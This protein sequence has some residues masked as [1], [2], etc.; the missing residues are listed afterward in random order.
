[1][2]FGDQIKKK[3]NNNNK[4]MMKQLLS[5]PASYHHLLYV[6]GGI[7]VLGGGRGL[8]IPIRTTPQVE[9][10]F[11]IQIGRGKLKFLFSNSRRIVKF[12]FHL[13]IIFGEPKKKKHISAVYRR[14]ALFSKFNSYVYCFVFKNVKLIVIL[15]RYV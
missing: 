9:I 11:Q 6:K 2:T 13:K 3:N 10:E 4:H 14:K 12:W 8:W 5:V 7:V 15:N 1:M